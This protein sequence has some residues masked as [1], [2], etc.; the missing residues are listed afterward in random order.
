MGHIKEPRGVD[1]IIKSEPLTEKEQA[2]IS[3]FIKNYKMKH[4]KKKI[5]SSKKSTVSVRKRTV[6]SK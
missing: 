1:F 5:I 3:E 4:T 2:A 6:A